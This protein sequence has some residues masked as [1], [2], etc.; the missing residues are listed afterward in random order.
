MSGAMINAD[1]RDWL[2]SQ[3]YFIDAHVITDITYGD[4]FPINELLA[5]FTGT[6]NNF[7]EAEPIF[8]DTTDARVFLD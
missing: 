8:H 4:P 7:R 2:K 6:I 5:R 3:D 1:Y